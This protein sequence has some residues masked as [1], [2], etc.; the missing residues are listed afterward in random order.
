LLPIFSIIQRHVP[1]VSNIHIKYCDNVICHESLSFWNIACFVVSGAVR[2]LYFGNWNLFKAKILSR[3][4]WHFQQFTSASCAH[5]NNLHVKTVK[6]FIH[7][8]DM[9]GMW[10]FLA[11]LSSFFHSSLLCTFSCHPSPPTILPSS[12]TSSCH[13]FLG[14]PLNLIVPKFIYNTLL[15]ILF[16][17]NL[18]THT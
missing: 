4:F 15:G 2:T 12:L 5:A 10:R 11:V 3:V 16:S 18:C 13:L 8:I 7:S 9:C 1:D 17:A 14:P 6:C